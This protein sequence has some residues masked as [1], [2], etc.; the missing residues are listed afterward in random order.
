VQFLTFN[1]LSMYDEE[2]DETLT[3]CTVC[4]GF[5]GESYGSDFGTCEACDG[6]GYVSVSDD[7][8]E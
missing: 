3:Y 7:E 6:T 2:D 8:E 5:G 4:G 1:F